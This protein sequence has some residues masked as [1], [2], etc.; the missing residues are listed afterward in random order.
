MA[1]KSKTGWMQGTYTPRHPEKYVGK[2]DQI[3]YR[4]SWELSLNKFLD[5]N[6]NV[7]Q[8]NSEEIAIPY[9]HPFKNKVANYYP[10]YWVKY[11]TKDGTIKTEIIEV[12]PKNQ[13]NRPKRGNKYDKMRWIV[14]MEKWKAAKMFCDHNNIDFRILT[15]QSLFI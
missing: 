14:N 5:N 12:K 2:V 6:P 11:K 3:Y 1:K 13:V 8:W 4:S 15:E 7:L 10:D 9:R